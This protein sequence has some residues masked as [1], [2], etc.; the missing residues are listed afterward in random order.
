MFRKLLL[1]AAFLTATAAQALA[2]APNYEIQRGD[3]LWRIAETELGSVWKYPEIHEMNRAVIGPDP[4][5]ILAGDVLDLPC[6]S[7]VLGDIDWS[8]M[9]TPA[10]LATLKEKIDIQIIDIRPEQLAFTG[11]IPGAIWVPFED[12]RG[13]AGNEGLPRSAEH[14]SLLLGKTGVR[15]DVPTIIVHS[16]TGPMK[17]GRSA[18]VYWVMKSL[19][20]ENLAILRGGHKAWETAGLPISEMARTT[21]TY[22]VSVTFSSQWRASEAEVAAASTGSSPAILLDARPHQMFNRVNAAGEAV[23]STIPGSWSL[24]A[25]SLMNALAGEVDIEDGVDTVIDSYRDS[26]ALASGGDIIT[27]CHV[28]E[29]AALNWFYASELASIP[30]VKVYPESLNGWG[31]SGRQLGTGQ[32]SGS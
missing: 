11:V 23:A 15:L 16:E 10:V 3:S 4:D 19:G 8:V 21:G 31:R 18:Y 20:A 1:G 2:C 12:W 14:Y 26:R 25:T 27:F 24:P 17:T 13:P 9:P 6:A 32:R 7:G 5:L 22:D 30:N 28:G 29:L